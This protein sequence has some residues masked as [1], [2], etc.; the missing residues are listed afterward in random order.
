MEM[1]KPRPSNQEEEDEPVYE[2]AYTVVDATK[3]SSTGNN[4]LRVALICVIIVVMFTYGGDGGFVFLKLSSLSEANKAINNS[5]DSG[6]KELV[7]I[8]ST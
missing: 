2:E 1:A 8:A 6:L 3:T 7:S 5:V 4:R